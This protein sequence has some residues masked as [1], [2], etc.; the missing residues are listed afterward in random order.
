MDIV[1][2]KK[3]PEEVR[4]KIKNSLLEYHKDNPMSPETKKKISDSKKGV[5]ISDQRKKE[6]GF[7]SRSF[8]SSIS[9]ERKKEITRV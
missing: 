7:L 5:H 6:I 2:N 8:W 4:Q 3:R 1:S 9:E